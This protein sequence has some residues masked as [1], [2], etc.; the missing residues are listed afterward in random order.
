M[1]KVQE[2]LETVLVMRNTNAGQRTGCR[3][4]TC[5]CI[6]LQTFLTHNIYCSYR[7]VSAMSTEIGGHKVSETALDEF[8]KKD[9]ELSVP[10]GA[11]R[12]VLVIVMVSRLSFEVDKADDSGSCFMVRLAALP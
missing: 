6:C 7:P 1:A 12:P 11:P 8:K 10:E 4:V 9:V 2:R 5:Y 3:T